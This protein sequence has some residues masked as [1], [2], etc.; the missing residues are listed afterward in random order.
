MQKSFFVIIAAAISVV[1]LSTSGAYS[2]TY[3]FG[4]EP[5]RLNWEYDPA[6]QSGCLPPR[7]AHPEKGD[8]ATAAFLI[9]GFVACSYS[10]RLI[11]WHL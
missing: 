8:K 10:L 3:P 1:L 9:D 2:G 6:V 4:D 7:S 11:R 5:Y